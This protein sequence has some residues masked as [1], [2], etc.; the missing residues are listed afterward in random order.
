MVAKLLAHSHALGNHVLAVGIAH[1]LQGVPVPDRQRLRNTLLQH[2]QH[3]ALI[4]ELQYRAAEVNRDVASFLACWLHLYRPLEPQQRRELCPLIATAWRTALPPSRREM[5]R[6]LFAHPALVADID[7]LVSAEI[8]TEMATAVPL[9]R[10]DRH[11]SSLVRRIRRLCRATELPPP[12]RLPVR[13]FVEKVRR[14]RIRSVAQLNEQWNSLACHVD[15]ELGR[16][17]VETTLLSLLAMSRVP[18]DHLQVLRWSCNLA[19][20]D[21]VAQ[22]YGRVLESREF[23]RVTPA[24]AG[25]FAV[26]AMSA[27]GAD[28]ELR[29]LCACADRH[30][31][32]WLLALPHKC[33]EELGRYVWSYQR[34]LTKDKLREWSA[35]RARA[36]RGRKSWASRV[37]RWLG[38]RTASVHA[39][40]AGNTVP[41]NRTQGKS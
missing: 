38:R 32:S 35:R 1:A 31:D 22:Q 6:W 11:V 5:A 27:A 13:D 34:Q 4:L 37:L 18:A 40:A 16:E 23:A 12:V 28:P 15:Q 41:R 17:V 26:V 24:A 29:Q 7:R 25:A 19:E 2:R 20:T 30:F 33:F 14:R 36:A 10:S 9:D 8:I 39:T 21:A 3:R